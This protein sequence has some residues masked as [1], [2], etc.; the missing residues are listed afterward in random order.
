MADDMAFARVI[1]RLIERHSRDIRWSELPEPLREDGRIVT[2]EGIMELPGYGCVQAYRLA[3]GEEVF[4]CD[5]LDRVLDLE[6]DDD[7][8]CPYC[9]EDDCEASCSGAILAREQDRKATP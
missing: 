1:L 2:H 4:S 6:E 5:D 3:D 8:P 9:G 7:T